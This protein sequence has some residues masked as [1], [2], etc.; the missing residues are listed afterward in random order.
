MKAKQILRQNT[1]S[2]KGKY[3]NDQTNNFP[4][5]S[6]MKGR[7]QS[8]SPNQRPK[9]HIDRVFNHVHQFLMNDEFLEEDYFMLFGKQED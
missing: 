3:A 7:L 6:M 1:T 9:P 4:I 8:H 5:D 2:R